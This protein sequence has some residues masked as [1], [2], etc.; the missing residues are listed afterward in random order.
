MRLFGARP[1][2]SQ[3]RDSDATLAIAIFCSVCPRNASSAR[4]EGGAKEEHLHCLTG[5]CAA[6]TKRDLRKSKGMRFRLVE[7]ACG[8][9]PMERLW[10]IIDVSSRDFRAFRSRPIGQS[11]RKDMVYS[12]TSEN[13]IAPNL[14]NRNFHAEQVNQK[15][16]FRHFAITY[17]LTACRYQLYWDPRGLV[18]F[19]RG[20]EKT[21]EGLH[22]S[23]GSRPE[24]SRTII[25]NSYASMVSKSP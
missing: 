21:T 11:Q 4:E 1:L 2:R 16:P 25:R 20:P 19:G 13:N 7:E 5:K 15:W 18:V 24:Y 17:Q 10:R 8:T 22:P 9:V 23:L 14:L 3:G 12:P 6:T